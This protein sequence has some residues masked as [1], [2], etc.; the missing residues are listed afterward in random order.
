LHLNFIVDD[1]TTGEIE[2]LSLG[3]TKTEFQPGSPPH[4]EYEYEFRVYL[5]PEGHPFCLIASKGKSKLLTKPQSK[6]LFVIYSHKFMN[7]QF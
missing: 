2:V 4:E 3:A 5:D 1:L 7:N 6:R